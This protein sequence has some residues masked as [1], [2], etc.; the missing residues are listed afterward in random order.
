MSPTPFEHGLALAWS[1]GALSRQG[2][3]MLE[4]LQSKLNLSDLDRAVQ[5]EKWLG[6]IS[7][8]NRRSFGD[9]DG[10]LQEWLDSLNDLSSLVPSVQMMGKAALK[11]GL[12]KKTW[13]DASTFANGLGLGQ[14]LAEGAWLE[15]ETEDLGDWPAALDPLAVIL[16]LVVEISQTTKEKFISSENSPIFVKVDLEGAKSETLSWMPELLPLEGEECA[17]GWDNGTEQSS[18]PPERDLVYCNSVLIAWVRRLVAKRHERGEAGLSGLPEGL[19]LMPSSSSL[20]IDGDGLTISMIID[21]GDSGLVRPWAKVVVDGAITAVPAPETLAPSWVGIHD[22]LAGLLIHGLQTLPRQLVLASGLDVECTN[23]S[24]DD[25]W[26]VH[27]LS[28]VQ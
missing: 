10:I 22:A 23:I 6:N 25:G 11:V 7:K 13:L 1:D 5:E 8:G 15:V 20:S 9:G 24:I 21:L 14:A 16:G 18:P 2:A 12:S 26:I 28:T 27:D 19:T 3:Q 4:N 17:W